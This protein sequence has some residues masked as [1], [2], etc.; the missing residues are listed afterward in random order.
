MAEMGR[1]L[2]YRPKEMHEDLE[3]AASERSF[4]TNRIGTAT[5]HGVMPGPKAKSAKA[6]INQDRGVICWPF[7]G[8]CAHSA[9]T[10]QPCCTLWFAASRGPVA[11]LHY[12]LVALLSRSSVSA[13]SLSPLSL[14]PADNEAVLCIFDGH[15]PR[16]EKASEFCM[17]RLP[18]LLEADH[19][20][21]R[22][23]PAASL[24]TAFVALDHELRHTADCRAHMDRS[25]TTAT[26]LYMHGDNLWVACVGDSRA[27]KVG[28]GGGGGGGVSKRAPLAVVDLS[29]DQKPECVEERARIESC[30]GEVKRAGKTGTLRVWNDGAVG[31][32]VTRSIGDGDV[33]AV[34]VI[35]E[36]VVRHFT[37][38]PAATRVGGDGD[39]FLLVASDGVWEFIPSAEAAEVVARTPDDATAGCRALVQLAKERWLLNEALHR[40]DVTA[41]VAFLPFLEEDAA[42]TSLTSSRAASADGATKGAATPSAPPASANEPSWPGAT[43]LATPPP[44]RR[45]ADAASADAANTPLSSPRRYINSGEIGISALGERG[46]TSGPVA[47]NAPATG[48]TPSGGTEQGLERTSSE[49]SEGVISRR[50]TVYNPYDDDGTEESEDGEAATHSEAAGDGEAGDGCKFMT[51]ESTANEPH[52]ATAQQVGQTAEVD[53]TQR[54][55][56]GESHYI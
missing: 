13:P 27:I 5:L 28:G 11:P 20:A 53:A 36:P 12:L 25:G 6:K 39:L 34:G 15:G 17:C 10:A 23:D 52:V 42:S 9:A 35:A 50:L 48:A 54:A 2:S 41:I 16:G 56:S 29:V 3:A 22:C 32:A 26:A 7:C 8:S 24:K 44:S 51:G 30:G 49:V 45:G 55:P 43:T 37:L 33:K 31:L 14:S 4:E 47:I 18:E 19:E 1:T 21:L 40:D 46:S 38:S